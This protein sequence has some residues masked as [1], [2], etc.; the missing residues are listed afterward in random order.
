MVNQKYQLILRRVLERS[1]SVLNLLRS[2]HHL[3]WITWAI[4]EWVDELFR[5]TDV[6]ERIPIIGGEL[7]L[8]TTDTSGRTEIAIFY[9]PYVREYEHAQRIGWGYK[10][11]TDGHQL[12][13][14]YNSPNL[15][16]LV[17]TAMTEHSSLLH[18]AH[19]RQLLHN[20]QSKRYRYS[21]WI[22]S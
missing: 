17:F 13:Y 20:L 8:V 18:L 3:Q 19:Y 7:P 6:Q 15:I 2:F 10:I 5:N 22:W 14:L 16:N 4:W 12:K 9:C 1:E 21:W 11:C